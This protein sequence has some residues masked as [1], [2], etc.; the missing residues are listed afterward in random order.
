MLRMR[1]SGARGS[2]REAPPSR[3]PA[4]ARLA[5]LALALL[6]LS[7]EGC[8]MFRSMGN[9]CSPCGTGLRLPRLFNHKQRAAPCPEG[10]CGEAVG[11]IPME[12]GAPMMGAPATIAPAEPA[13]DSAIPDLKPADQAPTSGS[14]PKSD[15][16]TGSATSKSGYQ[17]YRPSRRTPPAN[18]GGLVRSL[19]RLE[20]VPQADRGPSVV[21]LDDPLDS[22][23]APEASTL[24]DS[25]PRA[26]EVDAAPAVRPEPQPEPTPTP[27]TAA[28]PETPEPIVEAA[29][30]PTP[31]PNAN[32]AEP[33]AGAVPGIARFKVVAPQ[34]AGGSFPTAGGW[35]WLAEKRYRTV[36]DL[37]EPGQMGPNDLAEISHEGFRYIALPVT[38]RGID[39]EL[40]K[41]FDREL[42]QTDA[43]PLFF[44]DG[45][46]SR[47]AVLWYLHRV[48]TEKAD[49][50]SAR[51]EAE[52]LAPIDPAFDRAAATLIESLDPPKPAATA[53][54]V[55]PAEV[56][57]AEEPAA[58]REIEASEPT[59]TPA[60]PAPV[61]SFEAADLRPYVALAM[62]VLGVPLAFFGRSGLGMIRIRTRAS[63]PAPRR[64]PKSLPPSSGA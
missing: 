62:A 50:Q 9:G 41:R 32:P 33:V 1:R 7:Q 5:L 20:R 22:L 63:L 25:P 10:G 15:T 60:D 46:G 4:G 47:P 14:A 58:P 42:A 6:A 44:C 49:R 34:L 16:T 51:R 55:E 36:L 43:R 17:T 26:N 24:A 39:A 40:L 2:A 8:S 3:R 28:R 48:L 19:P 56:V 30:E 23:P 53:A 12:G 54:A 29:P 13:I 37:R 52:A 35:A 59:T 11:G 57:P 31:T 18:G 45:D 27:T 64:S 38:A 61:A 21:R